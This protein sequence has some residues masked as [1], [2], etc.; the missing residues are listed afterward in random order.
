MMNCWA[1]ATKAVAEKRVREIRIETANI[2][3]VE[4]FLDALHL[5][6]C[7]RS[8]RRGM[9]MQLE[10]PFIPEGD[11]VVKSA[12]FSEFLVRDLKGLVLGLIT[13]RH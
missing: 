2:L 5:E 8:R 7:R 3:G 4:C 11:G 6:H 10:A 12:K 1:A 9:D 13:A